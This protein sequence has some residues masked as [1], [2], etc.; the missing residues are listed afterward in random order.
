MSVLC[1]DD[2]LH[3]LALKFINQR[4]TSFRFHMLGILSK[5]EFVHHG[6]EEDAVGDRLEENSENICSI[7]LQNLMNHA[8]LR[9]ARGR[10]EDQNLKKEYKPKFSNQNLT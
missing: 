2:F 1:D 10:V 4:Q 3:P 8:A 6:F 5:G 9:I 7:R